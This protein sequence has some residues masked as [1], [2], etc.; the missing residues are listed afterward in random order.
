MYIPDAIVLLVVLVHVLV[1]FA[2]AAG[3]F[4]DGV[5]ELFV[6]LDR[7]ADVGLLERLVVPDVAV[8]NIFTVVFVVSAQEARRRGCLC[9]LRYGSVNHRVV[10]VSR[11]DLAV[12][13]VQGVAFGVLG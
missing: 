3:F 1:F 2:V 4:E 11:S 13:V 5:K 7:V 8:A 9:G 12:T 6:L 10:G